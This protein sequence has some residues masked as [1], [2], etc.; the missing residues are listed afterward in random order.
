MNFLRK[1]LDELKKPFEKGQK[2]EKF[3][4]AINAFDTFLFVP[5]HTT[6]KGAHIRDAVDLKRTM[7]TVIIALLPALIYGI[8]NTGYQYYAQTGVSFTFLEAFMHGAWKIVPMI[9]VS[10]VVGLSIEF[11]FAVYRG[12]EVNEGYLV[13][14]LLIPMI[15]PVDIPLWMVAV[16]TAFAV[17]IAKE[18]FGGTGM[19]IL[20]PALTARAFAFFAYPTYMSGNKV[21][22]SE[23]SN[24]DAISGETILGTL[25]AGGEVNYSMFEMF[26]GAIPGSIAET[27]TLWVAVGA[28]ILILTGVGS[29]RIITGGIL[30]AAVMGLL[31]NLWG[32]NALMSFSWI[33]HLVVGGFAFGIVFMATDPVSGAQTNKGKWIYG[34]LVGIFCIMIRVFNPAYPEG[35]ML[36]ILLMNVFAPTIDHYVVNGNI[37]KRKKRWALAQELKSA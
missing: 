31:F 37:K 22:V 12:H 25:A 21:W 23:A 15:M 19:N 18:A 2:L 8:Y 36:A 16:S 4:P 1:T 11:G 27:S 34:I 33:N 3:A 6:Q 20:N 10:Y 26:Q 35:V 29:W 13:T 28:L 30:G 14:G 9:I 7:V 32:A 5:N 24:V 17:L